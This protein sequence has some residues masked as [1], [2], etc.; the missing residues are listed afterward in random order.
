MLLKKNALRNKAKEIG[1]NF[2][3][4]HGEKSKSKNSTFCHLNELQKWG[5]EPRIYH[6]CR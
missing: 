5:G 2:Y 3:K 6:I 1:A 4:V